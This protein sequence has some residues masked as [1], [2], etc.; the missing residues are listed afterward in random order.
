M[1]ELGISWVRIGEFAWAQLEPEPSKLDFAWL[2]Q[3]IDI[4]GAAGLRVVLSTPTPTPPKWLVDQMPDMLA[5]DADGRQRRFGSRRHYC[6]SHAGYQ[7][8]CA[9]IVTALAQRFG[10]HQHV[11]AW[12]LDNEYGCHNTTLSYSPAALAAYR[13]W[14][15]QHYAT[16]EAL[17]AAWGNDFWSMR[18]RDFSEVDL[19]NSS[20]TQANPAHW[21]SFYRFSSDQTIAFNRLQCQILRQHSPDKPLLHNF[22]GMYWD[23]DHFELAADLDIA[24][25]DSYPLGFFHSRNQPA[26]NKSFARQG[27]PDFQAFHHDLYRAVGRGRWWVME[28]QPGPVNWAPWNPAPLTGMVELWGMEAFAHGAETVSYFRWRQYPQ[29]Q[30]QMHTGVLR[31]DSQPAPAAKEIARLADELQRLGDFPQPS[32]APVAIVVDYQSAW[33]WQILPQGQDFN[34]FE[35]VYQL[36]CALRA[37]GLNIDLLPAECHDFSAYTLLLIPGLYNWPESLNA[38][39]RQYQGYCLV[40]P[41][42]G[43]YKPDFSLLSEAPWP[44]AWLSLCPSMS[45]S[46]APGMNLQAAD[47]AGCVHKWFEYLDAGAEAAEGAEAEDAECAEAKG[48]ISCDQGN[49]LSQ[50]GRNFYL[51]GWPDAQLAQ[52]IIDHLLQHSGLAQLDLPAQLRCRQLANWRFWFNYGASPITAPISGKLLASSTEL[53]AGS[54]LAGGLP[55]ASW[56]LEQLD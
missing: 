27:D 24:S 17:N 4:L 55:A 18:Y 48:I 20:V 14:L 6:L 50:Q 22:M 9:R 2:Q 28:Q 13:R 34:Y 21:L 41:R 40:G 15:Q 31:P 11:H 33:A 45:E 26:Q 1:R 25:W 12:Q 54:L 38:A 42:S 16:I 39:L 29:A 30:E 5:L 47:G 35:L 46:L 44:R 51:S 7:A 43:N 8:E 19:P 49:I 53:T 36:Y 3:A 32:A 56:A 37:R 10:A 23:F 52:R